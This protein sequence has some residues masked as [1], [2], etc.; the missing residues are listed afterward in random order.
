MRVFQHALVFHGTPA[1]CLRFANPA[2]APTNPAN[3]ARIGAKLRQHAF[4]TIWNFWFFD[5]EKNFRFFFFRKIFGFGSVFHHFRWILEELG[6]FWRQNQI[7]GGFLLRMGGFSGP[8]EAWR[9]WLLIMITDWWLMNDDWW[10]M[11]NDWWLMTNEYGLMTDDWWQMINGKWFV[12]NDEW[13]TII[14]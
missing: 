3:M 8:Y 1:Y 7:P 14:D 4:R 5:A 6:L 2:E 10:L 13:P 11:T 9:Q 12:I